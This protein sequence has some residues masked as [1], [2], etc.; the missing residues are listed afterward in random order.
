[1]LR[2]SYQH[3][4]S[5]SPATTSA[6]TFRLEH[7]LQAPESDPDGMKETWYLF[8]PLHI[9]PYTKDD[10]SYFATQFRFPK[11]QAMDLILQLL[12]HLGHNVSQTGQEGDDEEEEEEEDEIEIL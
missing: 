2:L 4:T 7:V 3:L 9:L 8:T 1:M 5:I 11:Y 6:V 12:E 10:L